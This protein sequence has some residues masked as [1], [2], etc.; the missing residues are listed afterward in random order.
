MLQ[1]IRKYAKGFLAFALFGLLI[2]SFGV[3]GIGDVFRGGGQEATVVRVGGRSVGLAEFNVEL[4]REMRRLSAM[5]GGQLTLEQARQFGLLD[6]IADALANRVL[7]DI[8][9][10]R[11]GVAVSDELV[12]RMIHSDPTVLD[13]QGKF[14]RRRLD[15]VLANNQITEAAFVA[16][17]RGRIARDQLASAIGIG[18]GAPEI[19][20]KPLFSHRLE[21]RVA[22]VVVIPRAIFAEVKEPEQDQLNLFYKERERSFMA[23]EYRALTIVSFNAEELA[24]GIVVADA[25]LKEEYEVRHA[26]FEVKE[27]R[28]TEQFLLPSKDDADRVYAELQ[29]GK[30]YAAAARAATGA[31]AVPTGE[32]TKDMLAQQAPAMAETVFAIEKPGIVAPTQ[33]PFGW[34]IF[35]VTKITPGRKKSFDEAKP[36]LSK[37]LAREQAIESLYQL[38]NKVE[39]ELAGGASVEDVAKRQG[40]ATQKVTATDIQGRDPKAQQLLGLASRPEVL[41]AAFATE[42]GRDSRLTELGGDSYFIVRV[43]GVTP[44][45]PRAL[46]EVRP[47]VVAAWKDDQREAMAKARAEALVQKAKSGGDLAALVSGERGLRVMLP[48]PFTRAGADPTHG[49]SPQLSGLLFEAKPGDV[50]MAPTKDGFAVGKLKETIPADP[51]KE[52]KIY[53]QFQEQFRQ[54][55]GGDLV[56]QYIGAIR[57]KTRIE[58]NRAAFDKLTN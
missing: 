53:A 49:L 6:R 58:V 48:A 28:T 41:R 17:L 29:K 7:F 34:H 15:A 43:E 3:W 26:E 57:A 25:R 35:R 47:L 2:L 33:S 32:L 52:P 4:Q 45:A 42:S 16:V 56:A 23:P 12:R 9:V 10:E 14:D 8:G 36:V 40:L 13:E 37:A 22:E 39:D 44:S 11:V 24:K 50:V 38:A 30:D 27:L 46:S 1:T 18:G 21:R 54:Q 31:A 20:L 5:S 19:M 55:I 51:A